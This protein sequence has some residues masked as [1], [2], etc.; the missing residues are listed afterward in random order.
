MDEQQPVSR[1]IR[2]AACAGAG[3]ALLAVFGWYLRPE[4]MVS[5][6]NQLWSCF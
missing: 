1:W 3:A 5:L 6:A 2:V 4:L